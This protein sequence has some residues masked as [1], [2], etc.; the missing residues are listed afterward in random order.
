MKQIARIFALCMVL[1]WIIP[2]FAQ[3]QVTVTGTVSDTNRLVLPYATVTNLTTGK[4]SITDQGGF[5]KINASKG[6]LLSVTFVGYVSDTVA[7]T[8]ASGTQVINI[9]M[10]VTSKF[11]KGVDISSKFSPYQ[12]DSIARREQYGYILDNPNKP[13]AGGNTPQGAGIV[14][15]PITRFS[16][17]ERQKRQFKENY[18][19]MEED[20]YIDSRFTPALVSRVTGLTG[21]SLQHFMRDNYPSYETMRQLE[22]NNLLY[23]ITDKYK[24]W[25]KK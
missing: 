21:D 19:K 25:L 20:K 9:R 12:L 7:V 18:E 15:S 8:Q 1:A 11:L 17:K 13:L 10:T 24:A 4:H 14:F 6:D 22:N 23:W 16:K 3:A 2:Q 5:Y